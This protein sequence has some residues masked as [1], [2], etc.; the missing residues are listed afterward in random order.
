MYYT[1]L[2]VFYREST[3]LK[4]EYMMVN[5]DSL[6]NTKKLAAFGNVAQAENE[7][8]INPNDGLDIV[9]SF[10][11][12]FVSIVLILK[13]E[14]ATLTDMEYMS[15][16]ILLDNNCRSGTVEFSQKLWK[17]IGKPQNVILVYKDKSIFI[18]NR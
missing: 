8:V 12:H 4:L 15:G 7:I 13:I 11:K 3:G 6:K 18:V 9:L 10:T 14:N 1:V 2:N 16:C 5:G 17:K